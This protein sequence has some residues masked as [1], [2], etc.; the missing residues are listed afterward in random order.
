MKSDPQFWPAVARVQAHHTGRMTLAA[1]ALAALGACSKPGE[2]VAVV[3]PAPAA[4]VM[5]VADVDVTTNVKTALL[6]EPTLKSFDITVLTT[7]GDV[8]ITGLMVESHLEEG[9]QDIVVGQPLRHGVSVTDACI[10]MAQTV[11]VLEALAAAVRA[12]RG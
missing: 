5:A 11:P 3:P 6:N 12:R 1:C 10:S 7:Q 8:R 9:R 4:S 2:V